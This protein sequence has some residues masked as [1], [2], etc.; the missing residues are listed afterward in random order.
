MFL[1]QWYTSCERCFK[2]NGLLVQPSIEPLGRV[3]RRLGGMNLA[4]GPVPNELGATRKHLEEVV[5]RVVLNLLL[6]WLGQLC[7]FH[8]EMTGVAQNTQKRVDPRLRGEIV[9]LL[10]EVGERTLDR[11]QEV[12]SDVDAISLIDAVQGVVG[13][14]TTHDHHHKRP[15]CGV[16][17]NAVPPHI[18]RS[19]TNLL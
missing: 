14:R 13:H 19:S 11:S 7:Q 4:T 17:E 10:Q 1:G 5:I 8:M 16:M 6:V 9:L 15:H 2:G 3:R 18:R 12:D